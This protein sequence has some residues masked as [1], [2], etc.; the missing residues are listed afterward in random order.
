MTTD[1]LEIWK[2]LNEC[3]CVQKAFDVS[4]HLDRFC[5]QSPDGRIHTYFTVAEGCGKGFADIWV[6]PL[7]DP[8]RPERSLIGMIDTNQWHVELFSS[9]ILYLRR[10]EDDLVIKDRPDL[11]LAKAIIELEGK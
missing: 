3:E 8:I 1:E 4:Q 2:R 10:Y 11:A 9:S 7:Y 5:W 6:P